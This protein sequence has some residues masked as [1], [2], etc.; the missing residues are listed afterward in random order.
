LLL[1]SLT[2]LGSGCASTP[3]I[4]GACSWVKIITV[5]RQD[6]LTDQTA[7]EILQHNLKVEEVCSR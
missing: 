6:V 5:S 3:A 7:R 2:T 4:S 1:L